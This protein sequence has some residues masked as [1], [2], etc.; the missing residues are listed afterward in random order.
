MIHC[1]ACDQD[2]DDSCF[3]SVETK[4][5]NNILNSYLFDAACKE[6]VSE[7]EIVLVNTGKRPDLRISNALAARMRQKISDEGDW[8]FE[9]NAVQKLFIEDYENT[10][11][12]SIAYKEKPEEFQAKIRFYIDMGFLKVKAFMLS[13][14]NCKK[15]SNSFRKESFYNIEELD[16]LAA[17]IKGKKFKKRDARI[18]SKLEEYNLDQNNNNNLFKSPWGSE[19]ILQPKDKT[20]DRTCSVCLHV[21]SLEAFKFSGHDAYQCHDCHRTM[22]QQ[23]Y[24]NQPEE[25]KIEFRKK[26][27]RWRKNNPDKVREHQRGKGRRFKFSESRRLPLNKTYTWFNNEYLVQFF[28]NDPS[29]VKMIS[30]G[31]PGARVEGGRGGGLLTEMI[32]DEKLGN[33]RENPVYDESGNTIFQTHWQLDHS[34]PLSVIN[35]VCEEFGFDNSKVYANYYLNLRPMWQQENLDKLDQI[36]SYLL[37][38][39]S[40]LNNLIKEIFIDVIQESELF[41]IINYFK[42]FS[43]QEDV[44]LNLFSS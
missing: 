12:L 10:K 41:K 20:A 35:K 1:N 36:A 14:S 2:K 34:I 13:K 29:G 9:W 23:R 11:A 21:K 8:T 16:T 42:K 5:G 3:H 44:Q 19:Y 32:F 7:D 22:S 24:E 30:A 6:C 38:D 18:Y 31:E 17:L 43:P 37:E 4:I 39:E 40:Q 15:L 27:K 33:Q 26:G 25:Y 28:Y